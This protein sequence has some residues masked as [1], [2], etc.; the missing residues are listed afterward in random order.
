MV[1]GIYS[2]TDGLIASYVP[3]IILGAG[4]IVLIRQ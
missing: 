4:D 3:G 1:K 2:F